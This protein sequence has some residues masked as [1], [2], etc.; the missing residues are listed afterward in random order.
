MFSHSSFH[1]DVRRGHGCR[2][3]FI[4]PCKMHFER[5]PRK[6]LLALSRHTPL[7]DELILPS[8]SLPISVEGL[9]ILNIG[10][11]YIDRVRAG[12]SGSTSERGPSCAR[13][14][15]GGAAAS[16]D[17]GNRRET[18]SRA[19]GIVSQPQLARGIRVRRIAHVL[20]RKGRSIEP[21][22]EPLTRTLREIAYS[23]TPRSRAE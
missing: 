11:K 4:L 18:R 22:D 15:V 9:S 7:N 3:N 6:L 5:Y 12:S 20:Y 19:R 2:Q 23:V 21:V 8:N 1:P 14:D 16:R 10:N 17:D 13:R